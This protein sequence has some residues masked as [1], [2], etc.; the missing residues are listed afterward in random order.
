MTTTVTVRVPEGADYEAVITT[1]DRHATH[2][3]AYGKTEERTVT[4]RVKPG[5]AWTTYVYEGR[6]V[7]VSE[8]KL[9][10]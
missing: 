9:H 3:L 8:E 2:G 5:R 6:S 1:I 4:T 7:E 10:G